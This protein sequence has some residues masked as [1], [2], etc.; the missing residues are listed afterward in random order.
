[1]RVPAEA[2]LVE[3]DTNDLVISDRAMLH[4]RRCLNPMQIGDTRI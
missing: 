1:M 3:I 4:R 2:K